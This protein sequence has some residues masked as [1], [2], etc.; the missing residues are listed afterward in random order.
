VVLP[1]SRAQELEADRLG[2][3]YMAR[4][5]F[6]PRQAAAFWKRFSAYQ[7]QQGGSKSIEF[8][9]THPL[10]KTRIQALEQRMGRA[11]AEYEK[12]R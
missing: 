6:D 4:A 2:L 7:T 5:G 8:L 10:D 3:L 1:H 9:S 11:V 12:V